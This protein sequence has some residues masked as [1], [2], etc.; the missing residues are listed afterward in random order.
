MFINKEELQK[1]KDRASF[2]LLSPTA[3]KD[4]ARLRQYSCIWTI[5]ALA[6]VVK[7]HIDIIYPCVKGTKDLAFQKL[8]IKTSPSDP[9]CKSKSC[10]PVQRHQNL[11]IM[12]TK[13]LCA[14]SPCISN[15]V[16]QYHR[17]QLQFQFSKQIDAQT[18][19]THSN[20]TNISFVIPT[21]EQINAQT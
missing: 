4:C 8:N 6:N 13:P 11:I 9:S 5:L 20:Q 10:G 15:L 14:S 19:D 1:H 17:H 3:M 18:R 12:D 21:S 2:C 7:V 16:R